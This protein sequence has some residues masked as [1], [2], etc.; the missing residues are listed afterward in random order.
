MLLEVDFNVLQLSQFYL[1]SLFNSFFS[2]GSIVSLQVVRK[3]SDL[4]LDEL[5]AINRQK[6]T[7][8]LSE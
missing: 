6:H 3:V 5:V 4:S 1:D 7:L 2:K 8:T